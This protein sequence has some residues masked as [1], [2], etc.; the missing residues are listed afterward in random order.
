MAML[1]YLEEVKKQAEYW[2]SDIFKIARQKAVNDNNN[3][4]TS[5]D[6]L[7]EVFVNV[8]SIVDI[9]V[10]YSANKNIDLIVI[11]TRGRSR[12]KRSLLGS[13]AKGVV[14][15]AKCPVLLVRQ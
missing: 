14:E 9:I 11:G 5:I 13:I 8:N 1:L 4:G 2:F 12:I 7:A 6:I 3:N 10:N 15:C